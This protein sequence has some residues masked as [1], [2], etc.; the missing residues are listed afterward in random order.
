MGYKIIIKFDG[1]P[2]I[3]KIMR[4]FQARYF[5]RDKS[6]SMS[7]EKLDDLKE[8]L[9]YAGHKYVEINGD[10]YKLIRAE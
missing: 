2:E 3:V 7:K 8:E 9:T 1:Q 5:G 6:W 10:E 4:S